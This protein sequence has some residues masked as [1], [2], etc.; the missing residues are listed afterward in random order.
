MPITN[1]LIKMIIIKVRLIWNLDI[2]TRHSNYFWS[3][4]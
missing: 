2:C 3:V 4:A 1:T